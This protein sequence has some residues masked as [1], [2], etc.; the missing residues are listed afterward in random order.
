MTTD[1]E[2]ALETERRR[3]CGYCHGKGYVPGDP[4][5]DPIEDCPRCKGT[6]RAQER[7]T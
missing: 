7:T 3:D 1:R 6:G 5:A 4:E 2:K